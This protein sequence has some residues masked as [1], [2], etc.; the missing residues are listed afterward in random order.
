MLLLQRPDMDTLRETC[1]RDGVGVRP[2][3][4]H[5][6]ATTRTG[7]RR[8]SLSLRYFGPVVEFAKPSGQHTAPQVR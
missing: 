2:S 3:I 4:L 7:T 8:R 6:G 1:E 5:E